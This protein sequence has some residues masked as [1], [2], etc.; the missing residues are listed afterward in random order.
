MSVYTTLAENIGV[1]LDF[2]TNKYTHSTFNGHD[3]SAT[4][5]LIDDLLYITDRV[6]NKMSMEMVFRHK[7]PLV[8]A[9]VKLLEKV[10]EMYNVI[11]NVIEETDETKAIL[12]NLSDVIKDLVEMFIKRA[13][14][15]YL[16][17]T[18]KML[19]H[20]Y[21][22]NVIPKEIDRTAP[23]VLKAMV[24][25]KVLYWFKSSEYEHYYELVELVSR[26]AES[27]CDI[28]NKIGEALHDAVRFDTYL[29][30]D[31]V[32]N[33]KAILDDESL[34]KINSAVIDM[35]YNITNMKEVL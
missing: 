6:F 31:I 22:Y 17:L 5:D 16:C 28:D 18:E 9:L 20:L 3:V 32:E 27:I 24:K 23:G 2:I 33:I 7:Q 15:E 11:S 13:G 29:D 12:Y 4:I 1:L 21:V 26:Y 25:G 30:F 34:E 8:N 10:Y 19:E 14:I 35:K